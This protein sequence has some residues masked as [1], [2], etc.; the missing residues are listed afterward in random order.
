[1][2]R[3]VRRLS[4]PDT[5]PPASPFLPS[6]SPP[7][8]PPPYPSSSP[9][10]PIPPPPPPPLPN[11]PPYRLYSLI[12]FIG[13]RL[14]TPPLLSSSLELYGRSSHGMSAPIVLTVVSNFPAPPRFETLIGFCAV[15]D[16]T[17]WHVSHFRHG[18]NQVSLRVVRSARSR[19]STVSLTRGR[20][21]RAIP[22][23]AGPTSLGIATTWQNLPRGRP[24]GTSRMSISRPMFP[25]RRPGAGT[26]GR[27]RS[28][29]EDVLKLPGLV[30]VGLGGA[31]EPEDREPA[32]SRH[33]GD[34]VGHRRAVRGRRRCRPSRRR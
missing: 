23:G 5:L 2:R 32:S 18:D 7:P 29:C 1:M 16:L 12:K 26:S 3:C 34:P 14:Y 27:V 19:G 21:R 15:L 10:S 8:S 20:A 9:T 11:L 13:L 28:H 30:E 31:V 33:G 22:E 25:K 4:H 6:L 24:S 17:R